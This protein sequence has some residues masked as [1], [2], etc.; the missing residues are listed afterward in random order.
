MKDINTTTANEHEDPVYEK[1]IDDMI[2]LV[3]A[4]FNPESKENLQNKLIRLIRNE[5]KSLDFTEDSE[6]VLKSP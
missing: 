1:K 5:A 2:F 3:R 4:H 6:G